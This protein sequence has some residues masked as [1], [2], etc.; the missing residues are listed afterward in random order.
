[1]QLSRR[2]GKVEGEGVW[3]GEPDVRGGAGSVR[4]AGGPQTADRSGPDGIRLRVVRIFVKYKEQ[5]L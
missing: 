1:M 5:S 4:L 2:V 3:G